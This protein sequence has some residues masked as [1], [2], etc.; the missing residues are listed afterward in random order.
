MPDLLDNTHLS[1]RELACHDAA[2]TPYP[3]EFRTDPTRLPRVIRAFEDV[4]DECGVEL[5]QDCPVMVL[6]AYRTPEHQASLRDV[7][8]MKSAEHSQHVEGRAL[9]LACSLPFSKFRAAVWRA[10]N[11]PGS[12]IRYIEW[13]KAFGYIHIDVRPTAKVQTETVA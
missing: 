10:A 9:D 7:P 13:R 12:P 5:G 2:H 6:S 4:R 3:L 8:W 1:W 11:R